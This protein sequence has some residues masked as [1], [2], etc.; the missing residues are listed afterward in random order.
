MTATVHRLD[1]DIELPE[2]LA[3]DAL[4]LPTERAPDGTGVYHESVV[5]LAKELRAADVKAEYQ[6]D[7]ASRK[8][9]GERAVP[10]VVLELFVALGAHAAW[11]GIKS[12]LKRVPGDKKV[13]VRVARRATPDENWELL[14]A[15]GGGEEVADALGAALSAGGTDG[16]EDGK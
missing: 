2:E 5:T 15:E 3:C 16:R 7:A 8:W 12:I 9:Y 10:L 1:L 11:D 4:I 13:R 14:E 6:D